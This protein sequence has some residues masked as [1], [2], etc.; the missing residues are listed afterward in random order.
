MSKS[1]EQFLD[2]QDAHYRDDCFERCYFCQQ[3]NKDEDDDY[4]T[5]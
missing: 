2:M 4:E 1:A 3:L 5:L